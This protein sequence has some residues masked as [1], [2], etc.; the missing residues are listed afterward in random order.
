VAH[1]G[2]ATVGDQEADIAEVAAGDANC[3]DTTVFHSKKK[4]AVKKSRDSKY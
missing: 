1:P 4:K 3:P 2:A